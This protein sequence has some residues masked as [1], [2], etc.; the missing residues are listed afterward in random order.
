MPC[1]SNSAAPTIG[2]GAGA[3]TFRT[4]TREEV[5]EKTRST[6]VLVNFIF[7]YLMSDIQIVDFYRLLSPDECRKYVLFL[8][9]R[10][11]EGFLSLD[12][13]PSKDRSGKLY[14]RTVKDHVSPP[15]EEEKR[16]RQQTCLALSFF[17]VRIFQ[18]FGALALTLV[19]DATA[20][21]KI[22]AGIDSAI[23]VLPVGARPTIGR[24]GET[25]VMART[26]LQRRATIG[27]GTLSDAR[28]MTPL[29]N[30][31]R[32]I[33]GGPLN[34][35]DRPD[36]KEFNFVPLKRATDDT[37]KS[38]ELTLFGAKQQFYPLDTKAPLY[39]AYV[40]ESLS[41]ASRGLLYLRLGSEVSIGGLRTG[42]ILLQMRSTPLRGKQWRISFSNTL[43][44]GNGKEVVTED[45]NLVLENVVVMQRDDEKDSYV[46]IIGGRT[47][48]T[49]DFFD[50]TA[51]LFKERILPRIQDSA[52]A[53]RVRFSDDGFA[54]EPER[55]SAY[56]L[57]RTRSMADVFAS[58]ELGGIGTVDR[59]PGASSYLLKDEEVPMGMRI[60]R[61]EYAVRQTKPLPTCVTRAL[62]L[63]TTKPAG[64]IAAI[65]S[66]CDKGFLTEDY[67]R[68]RAGTVRI[69]ESLDKSPGIAALAQLFYDTV[70]GP[71]K[72]AMSAPSLQSYKAFMMAMGELLGEFKK[73]SEMASDASLKLPAITDKY[74]SSL[75]DK[76][77]LTADGHLALSAETRLQVMPYVQMLFRRQIEH[78]SNAGAI[79]NKLFKIEKSKDGYMR[80]RIQP[81]VLDGGFP[82]LERITAATREILMQYYAGC[83]KTYRDGVA[84][85]AKAAEKSAAAKAAEE[86]EAARV[87]AEEAEKA[88]AAARAKAMAVSEDILKPYAEKYAAEKA[89]AAAGKATEKAKKTEAEK[90][91]AGAPKGI[92]KRPTTAPPGSKMTNIAGVLKPTDIDEVRRR[93]GE[94]PLTK[95]ERMMYNLR[96]LDPANFEKKYPLET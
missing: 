80:I 43:L 13:V 84:V 40:P 3:S 46:V 19:D 52:E 39:F 79:L 73:G 7:E 87:K 68:R 8:A 66:I 18:I 96:T 75:C 11:H 72:L 67:D 60:S 85:I 69:G 34:S 51:R 20:M 48:S 56:D 45:L 92:L 35:S 42:S 70:T 63:L 53:R 14:Y 33:G 74:M 17:Y 21:P 38:S 29:S 12:I 76:L 93:A 24:I 1:G 54:R 83:E 31:L 22:A 95:E 50:V 59:R 41:G 61:M 6:Q 27:S 89:A 9:S 57:G 77:A 81:A 49:N 26:P 65:S 55:R 78:A 2:M 71:D 23:G 30:T 15:T 47:I 28:G 62:Q 5:I 91:A 16:F 82:V 25:P 90:P 88:K 36:F 44:L 94:K 10:I 64:G 4:L 86:A 37:Y 32:L 58:R